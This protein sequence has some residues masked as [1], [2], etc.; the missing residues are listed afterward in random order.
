MVWKKLWKLNW[1]PKIKQFLWRVEHNSHVM[2]LNIKR[3]RID[4]DTRCPVCWCLDED[5][6]HYFLKCKMARACWRGM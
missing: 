2:K 1:P 3:R 5:G 4:L 6:G